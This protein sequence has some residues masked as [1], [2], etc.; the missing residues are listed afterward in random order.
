MKTHIVRTASSAGRAFRHLAAA[1]LLGVLALGAGGAWAQGASASHNGN[2]VANRADNGRNKIAG[3]LD[4]YLNGRGN[5]H[6][7][8]VK[9][10]VGGAQV[11]VIVVSNAKND[12]KLTGIRRA[13]AA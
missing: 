2:G 4:A 5:G 3:D 11:N 13:V 6:E 7:S 10:G 9:P 8:W 12:P 1:A